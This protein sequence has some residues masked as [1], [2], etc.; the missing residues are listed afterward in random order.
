MTVMDDA[1]IIQR[2]MI[3]RMELFTAAQILRGE[4]LQEFWKLIDDINAI[5]PK[6]Y[7]AE[8]R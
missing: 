5:R 2:L 4:P 7:S 8:K 6:V 3:L 1:Q